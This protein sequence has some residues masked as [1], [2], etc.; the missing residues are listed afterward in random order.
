MKKILV[1][2]PA[3]PGWPEWPVSFAYVLACLESGGVPF[4]F[5]DV[6]TT[7]NWERK[8]QNLLRDNDYLT[9]ASGGLIGFHRFFR[10]LIAMVRRH[11]PG[12]PFLLGGNII[13][14]GN[15]E[16]LFETI[17]I[18][19]AYYGE[20]EV[21]VVPFLQALAEGKTDFTGFP[22][23]FFRDAS[24]RVVRNP[25]TRLDLTG[26]NI[27][28][29]WRHFDCDFYISHSSFAFL[30]TH[31]RFMPILSGRGCIGKCGFCSPS[32][33]GFKKRPI[34]HVIE[35]IRFLSE[36]YDFDT[37]CFLNEMFYPT[38]KEVR[39]FCHAYLALE[40]RK[41]WFVQL[42]I[43]SK[44]D[45][46]TLRLMKK[47]GCIAVSA[48]IESG[49]D[50]ILRIMNKK[51]T[52]QMIREFFRNCREA[53]M[54]ASGTVII[55]YDRETEED[56]KQTMDLLIEED[57]S[58]GE[59]LL[60]AYQGTQV[61]AEAL[62]RGLIQDE[63][64]QLDACS[65]NLFQPNAPNLFCNLTAMEDEEFFRAATREVRRYYKHLFDRYRV[66][67]LR[68]DLRGG[69]RWTRM[70]LHGNC[71]ACNAEVEHSYI[72]FGGEYLG[73]LGP[74]VNRNII[75]PQ[76]F[77]PLA[78]DLHHARG[79]ESSLAHR[80]GLAQTLARSRR[81]L[82]CG[83]NNN[84]DFLLRSD[85]FGL[86]YDKV[87]GV[88]P[89]RPTTLKRYLIYPMLDEDAFCRTEA[90][91]ILCVDD[92]APQHRIE[93]LYRSRGL[94]PPSI[95]YLTS[96]A[97]RKELFRKRCLVYKINQLTKRIF[98]NGLRDILKTLRL[99]S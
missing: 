22:G 74:G 49:S 15:D 69:P 33:G 93:R 85:L 40:N 72:V 71:A 82:I 78:F 64:A 80:E 46:E 65:G 23:I 8:A 96:R 39:E 70:R 18:D 51:I 79:M 36:R 98:G 57:I 12:T 99:S 43:D 38:A 63:T 31:L 73:C 67:D 2:C 50:K 53:G 95:V 75:C 10:D 19:Y 87:V 61:Y 83:I 1:I 24:G 14:D 5:I 54:P 86:D 58:S 92:S 66:R 84:L 42:R 68:H 41:A 7:Q 28:P 6:A 29:A 91:C 13:K 17:G 56:L 30:G 16:L 34:E 94:R 88:L 48:G 89:T 9:V 21:S 90:D 55:G 52:N 20:A 47:A 62:R 26:P 97:F 37:L 3:T 27:L 25:Q 32:V 60:F 35:E 81:V 44:L 11:A 4:D 77:R 45:V 76:C 59:A